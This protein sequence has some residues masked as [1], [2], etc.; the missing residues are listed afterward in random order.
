MNHIVN[1]KINKLPEC[2][3]CGAAALVPCV[4]FRG[5]GQ[6]R[7]PHHVR[8]QLA[9]GELF[10]ISAGAARKAHLVRAL[11]ELAST[12]GRPETKHL[13]REVAALKREWR[14][15]GSRKR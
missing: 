9:R 13:E 2:P 6:V 4:T 8:E 15:D 10:V 14:I 3:E 1:A 12:I 5:G 7:E 11:R